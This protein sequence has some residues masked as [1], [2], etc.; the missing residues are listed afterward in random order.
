M[1]RINTSKNFTEND[2]HLFFWGSIYSQWHKCKFTDK[3]I[4]VTFNS[5]EQ[6]MM[7]HKAMYFSDSEVALKILSEK[8]PKEQKALGR[9]VK[10]YDDASWSKIRLG[11]VTDGNYLKFSQNKVLRDELLSTGD[12]VIVEGSPYDKIWGVGLQFDDERIEDEKNWN[13]EN[14]LGKALMEVRSKLRSPL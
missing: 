8:D 3:H 11:V 5:T 1:L 2:T 12:K 9:L 10:G 14:L 13:G 4:N 7:W 6:Y